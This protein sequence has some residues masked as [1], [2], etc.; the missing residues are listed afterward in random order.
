[1]I[2]ISLG[3]ENIE[4]VVFDVGQGQAVLFYNKKTGEAVLEDCRG[5][6]DAA[7]EIYHHIE[8]KTIPHR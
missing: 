1:M 2:N 7:K 3:N 8:G 5:T 4:N 6:R